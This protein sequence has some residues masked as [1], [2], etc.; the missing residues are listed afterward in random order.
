L[1]LAEGIAP[2]SY[3]PEGSAK[4]FS[5]VVCETRSGGCVSA[6]RGVNDLDG[7]EY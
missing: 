5:N 1:K 7:P 2:A 3:R 4:V 6:D